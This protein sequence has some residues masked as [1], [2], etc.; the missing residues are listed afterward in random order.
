MTERK[1]YMYVPVNEWGATIGEHHW[2]ARLTDKQIDEIRDLHEDHNISYGQLAKQF[3]TSKEA[4]AKI[5]RYERR[6]QTP[7][8]WKKIERTEDESGQTS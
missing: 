2:K 4:I 3:N 5:C 1:V 6:A 8:R 7:E